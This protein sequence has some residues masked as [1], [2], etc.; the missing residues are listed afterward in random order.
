ME[1]LVR[2]KIKN[3]PCNPKKSYKVF[4][5]VGGGAYGDVYKACNTDKCN[6]PVAVKVSGESLE[7]E[8]KIAKKISD[9]GSLPIVFGYEKCPEK[10]IMYSEFIPDGDLKTFIK[11]SKPSS[12][13]IKKIVVIVLIHLIKI[14]NKDSSFRHHDLHTGN[15]LITRT[16]NPIK[17][18]YGNLE[19][20]TN[21]IPMLTDLGLSTING[22]K[23]P[24]VDDDPFFF[25]KGYGIFK[26]SNK[27][28]D[29]HFLINSLHDSLNTV[30]HANFITFARS[31]FKK[32]EYLVTDSGKV[33]NYRLKWDVKHVFPSF[34]D[35]LKNSYFSTLKPKKIVKTTNKKYTMPNNMSAAKEKAL[36][37]LKSK[38]TTVQPKKMPSVKSPP[39]TKP[40][41]EKVSVIVQPK[42]KTTSQPQKK[43]PKKMTPTMSLRKREYFV[44]NGKKCDRYKKPVLKRRAIQ[45]GIDVSKKTKAM[46]CEQ[47][48]HKTNGTTLKQYLQVSKRKC[49]GYKKAD[50]QKAALKYGV[51][52]EKKT[53]A[54]L[55]D[56][57]MKKM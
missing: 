45:E 22:V 51:K 27:M 40:S 36:A 32:D 18:K 15:V 3:N 30:E 49:D 41:P 10:N 34:D 19:F 28:Y 42:K 12:I 46:L 54:M 26:E 5:R 57:I 23:N 25:K 13:E 44:L 43:K 39:R 33:K 50:I 55:C 52:I 38:K 14:S 20:N 17:I 8:Y 9:I 11:K 47:L 7:A 53:K 29:F 2:K 21:I 48:F 24:Q 6:K 4:K 16:V 31:I 35:I 37:I 1:N 56:E